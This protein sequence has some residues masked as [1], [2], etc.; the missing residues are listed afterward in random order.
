MTVLKKGSRGTTVRNLQLVLNS[1]L[2]PSPRLKPDG[3]FGQRTHNTVLAF[4]RARGLVVDGIVGRKTW[5]ALYG[6]TI[7]VSPMLR[8]PGTV[9]WMDIAVAEL[10]VHEYSKPGKHHRRILEYH[11]TTTLGARTDEV[12]W[13]SSFVNWVMIQSG[14]CGTNNALAKSWLDWGVEIKTP[15]RGSVA[16][17]QRKGV[18]RDKATGSRTGFHVAFL[19]NLKGSY[20]RL[21]GGNQGDRVKYSNFY[22]KSYEVKGYRW[23][24]ARGF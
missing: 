11:A 19:E 9:S 24:V 4:Q 5:E 15:R 10:G 13:C 23:P 17:I 14:Y 21:L 20:V 12:P 8:T 7:K 3:V 22:L 2:K 18:K 1:M 6:V 16:V